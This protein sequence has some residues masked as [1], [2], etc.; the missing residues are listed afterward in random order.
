MLAGRAALAVVSS[1]F[2]WSTILLLLATTQLTLVASTVAAQP[3]SSEDAPRT[4]TSVRLARFDG[5]PLEQMLQ[6]LS[7]QGL[8]ILFST[9]L[10]TDQMTVDV[11]V[12][13]REEIERGRVGV[14]VLN[15]LL[16]QW[17][18]MA[19]PGTG[20]VLLVT[21]RDSLGAVEARFTALIRSRLSRTPLDAATVTLAPA[22]R[23]SDTETSQQLSN[24]EGIVDFGSLK[25]GL[26]ALEVSR[27][28][29]LPVT[30]ERVELLPDELSEF[31]IE[32]E[33]APHLHEE[34][35]VGS[36]PDELLT[37]S[38][39]G[40]LALGR[41]EIEGI[42]HLGNDPLRALQLLPGLQ[43]SDNS[44]QFG[45]HGG[46]PDET[47][48]VLDGQELY[49][50]FHLPDFDNGL[51]VVSSNDL[52]SIHH[53]AGTFGAWH[54]DRMSS[55]LDLRTQSPER[56]FLRLGLSLLTVDLAGGGQ[57]GDSG[58]WLASTRRGSI[59]FA[60]RIFGTED[61][62]FWDALG[63][64]Q[65]VLGKQQ[66]AAR[67][68]VGDDGL[69]FGEAVDGL[70]KRFDTDYES[71]YAWASHD[72]GLKQHHL[73]QTRVAVSRNFQDR[74]GQEEDD[75]QDFFVED[76]REFDTTELRHD[77]SFQ[78][79][80]RL[81][82]GAGFEVRRY[83][84]D[85]S[86]RNGADPP[87]V[88]PS[89]YYEPR[90]STQEFAAAR[91]G[92]HLGAWVS[93]RLTLSPR[94]SFGL[95]AAELGLR[96]DRH[97]LTDDTLVSPRLNLSF[98]LGDDTALHAGWGVFHQTQRPYELDLQDGQTSFSSAEKAR[99]AV[100][101]IE[102]SFRARPESGSEKGTGVSLEALR[103]DLHWSEISRPRPRFL[104][105]YEPIE[106][107]PEIEPDR[108]TVRPEI[109]RSY[110]LDLL[111]RGS[112]GPRTRWIAT[113]AYANVEDLLPLRPPVAGRTREWIPREREQPH[114]LKL[115]LSRDLKTWRI[116][117]AFHYRTGW[118]TTPIRRSPTWQNGDDESLFIETGPLNSDRVR[119]NH[120][121]DLRLSRQWKRRNR[122]VRF[123]I[124]IQ[125]VFDRKNIAGFDVSADPEEDELEI[126][127]EA[128]VGL[129]PSLG[130]SIEW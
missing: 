16:A 69:A 57:F 82:F 130:V 55:V 24:A 103:L 102:R 46:R 78:P 76:L 40:P 108:V 47:M 87:I 104:N 111:A 26:Y 54:G 12:L 65:K 123:F 28:G 6:S 14:A 91:R 79:N 42:P 49:R 33:L 68:L 35:V 32:L 4:A 30:G 95:A 1:S 71:R 119:D 8:P 110:G 89:P 31:V 98:K 2:C 10:V 129:F 62:S 11:D 19:K 85:Y 60:N 84:V 67:V 48:V 124:D 63:K 72:V 43:A 44:A 37:E 53:E 74:R 5:V 61:P 13:T 45:V 25:P 90:A 50:A 3:S 18:L 36:R 127:D 20:G 120:R 23:S 22:G 112:I 83:D 96:Y 105:L 94:K 97:T 27:V 118:P 99:R 38:P 106:S 88:P 66:M 56:N 115:N 75:D 92:D 121:L 101:G 81:G 113:Y 52:A 7:D 9:A 128:F 100:L 51:S 70:E 21:R 34:I 59:E 58:S 114:T 39:A 116:D 126:S 29:L 41:R 109:S 15:S 122:T 17:D 64:V 125:N 73:F 107:F 77:W 80:D 86:Y 93:Q 117:L